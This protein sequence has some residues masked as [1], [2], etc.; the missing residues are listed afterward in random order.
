MLNNPAAARLGNYP[1]D[2]P[3]SNDSNLWETFDITTGLDDVFEQP[4][5]EE[6]IERLQNR[7]ARLGDAACMQRETFL[8][9]IR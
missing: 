3:F 8:L 6:I 7:Y 1:G 4:S 2:T 9:E 5:D